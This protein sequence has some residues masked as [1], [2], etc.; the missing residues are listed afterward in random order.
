M[1]ELLAVI[2][3]ALGDDF[4]FRDLRVKLLGFTGQSVEA[5]REFNIAVD[6]LTLAVYTTAMVTLGGQIFRK[7]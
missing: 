2:R 4:S 5:T 7:S 1:S 3:E 6:Y